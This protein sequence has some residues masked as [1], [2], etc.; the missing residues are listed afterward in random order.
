M[1]LTLITKKLLWNSST[2]I[3]NKKFKKKITLACFI[4]F[5]GPLPYYPLILFNTQSIQ[6]A[7]Q[8]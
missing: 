5:S 8:G 2:P 1:H 3:Q 7:A 4:N 6:N